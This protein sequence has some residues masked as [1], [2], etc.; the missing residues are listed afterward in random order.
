MFM[1]AYPRQFSHSQ[2]ISVSRMIPQSCDEILKVMA[3]PRLLLWLPPPRGTKAAIIS[4]VIVILDTAGEAVQASIR[5]IG[6]A[7]IP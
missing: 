3:P 7:K 1:A 2:T 6:I 4:W 5:S